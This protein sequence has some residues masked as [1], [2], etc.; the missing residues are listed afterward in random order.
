[1]E[2]LGPSFWKTRKKRFPK[3]F[4]LHLCR[5]PK[6]IYA[7]YYKQI[8]F[9]THTVLRQSACEVDV[10]SGYSSSSTWRFRRESLTPSTTSSNTTV[11]NQAK[12]EQKISH[13]VHI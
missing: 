4:S 13:T 6:N 5:T 11:F 12:C 2:G 7:L 10:L 3:L 9:N 1:M 8:Y